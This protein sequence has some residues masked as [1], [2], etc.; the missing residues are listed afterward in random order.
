MSASLSQEELDRLFENTV[1]ADALAKANR[2]Y[3]LDVTPRNLMCDKCQKPTKR[4]ILENLGRLSV[5]SLDGRIT[6]S[7]SSP[8]TMVMCMECKFKWYLTNN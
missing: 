7:G 6:Y 4:V 8:G 5:L 1:F 3:Y 2:S